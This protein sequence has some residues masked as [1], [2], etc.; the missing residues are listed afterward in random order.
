[1]PY[2]TLIS[3][4][5]QL[6]VKE[7]TSLPAKLAGLTMDNLILIDKHRG[8]YERHGILAEEIGH[9]ETT[10]GDIT[11]LNN[12]RNLKLELFAR[13]WGY[14]KI[15]SL[16]KLIEC[17]TLNYISL[18]EVCTYLEITAEYLKTSI[19]HYSSSLGISVIHEGYQIS[20]D[21]LFIRKH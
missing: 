15:V 21:P 14:K 12:V 20:F 9:Y 6:T 10:Y 11:D 19:D 5:P 16:D 7:V 18:E 17:Y 1:M 2:E 3:Q 4:Y 8:K 13:R